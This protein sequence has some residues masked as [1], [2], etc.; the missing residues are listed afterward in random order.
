M[1]SVHEATGIE[2]APGVRVA[3]SVIR[4]QYS[5]SGGPGG[6]NV[7]KLNT[8]AELWIGLDALAPHLSLRAAHR[9]ERL[10]GRRL[11]KE[12]E[13]HFSSESHRSQEQNRQE[14]MLRLRELLIAALIEPKPRRKTR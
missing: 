11:T 9:V 3:E 7:N 5:R 14:A 13:L 4:V 12:R 2:L 10:A 8:K 1:R 6:Q